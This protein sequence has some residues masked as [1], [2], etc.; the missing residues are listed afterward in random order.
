MIKYIP[1]FFLFAS[2]TTCKI[3]EKGYW[4]LQHISGTNKL[5]EIYLKKQ[6]P[7][8]LPKNY[9]PVWIPQYTKFVDRVTFADKKIIGIA[10]MGWEV[11]PD[12]SI[13]F[14]ANGLGKGEKIIKSISDS[15]TAIGA[16]AIN[17]AKDNI[18]LIKK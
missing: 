1:L 11:K 2:C 14:N 17:K 16:G 4:R 6:L 7:L 3:N 8:I 10:E 15:A 13:A 12:G 9:I 5:A 18:T